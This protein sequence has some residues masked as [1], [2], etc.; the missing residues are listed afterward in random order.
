[1]NKKFYVNP[2]MEVLKLEMQ[3]TVLEISKGGGDPDIIPDW[4]GGGSGSDEWPDE[5]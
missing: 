4:G 5:E 3:T 2:E 1:M